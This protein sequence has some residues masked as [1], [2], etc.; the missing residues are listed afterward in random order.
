MDTRTDTESCGHA[1]SALCVCTP[2]HT[3]TAS[4]SLL[5]AWVTLSAHKGA[6]RICSGGGCSLGALGTL[7][8]SPSICPV[9]ALGVEP[10]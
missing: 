4:A 2:A 3:S 6:V 1:H 10:S 8:P 5:C 7:W 9:Y